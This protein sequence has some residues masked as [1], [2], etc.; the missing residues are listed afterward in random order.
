MRDRD[1]TDHRCK[2]VEAALKNLAASVKTATVSAAELP[3]AANKKK[4]RS[5]RI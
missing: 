2:M 1:Q 4:G 5:R 3:T